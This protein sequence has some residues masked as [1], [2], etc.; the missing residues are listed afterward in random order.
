MFALRGRSRC[1]GWRRQNLHRERIETESAGDRSMGEQDL[2]AILRNLV[3][4]EIG[5]QLI[6]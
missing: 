1:F 2:D 4:L 3:V 6:Q 5:F